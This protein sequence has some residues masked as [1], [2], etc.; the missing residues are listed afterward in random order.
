[1][2]DP[3]SERFQVIRWDSSNGN[4][5]K[6]TVVVLKQVG[7]YVPDLKARPARTRPDRTLC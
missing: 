5:I 1:M 7:S 3:R 6:K 2:L 4:Q